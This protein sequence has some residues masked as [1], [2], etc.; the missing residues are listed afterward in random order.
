MIEVLWH[1]RGGQGAFTAA[2]LLGAAG[3]LE[4]G[5]YG[6][7]FPS[8]GPE[9]RGAPM[10]AFTK[11]GSQPVGDRSAITRADYTVFLDETLFTGSWRSE[12]KPGGLALVNTSCAIDEPDVIALDASGISRRVLGRDIPN[13]VFL[14]ALCLLIDGL[15]AAAAK[16]AIAQYMTP[17]LHEPNWAVVDAVQEL[18]QQGALQP[19]GSGAPAAGG[20][21]TGEQPATQLGQPAAA[22][23]PQGALIP[24]L[25]SEQLD[26]AVY[27]RSTCW[28]AGYLVS[29]NA[30]WRTM[31]PVLGPER[32]TGCLQCY[33]QCPDGTVFKTPDGGVAI[34]YDFCK[35]C[36]ICA[37]ACA[38][39]CIQ[40]VAEGGTR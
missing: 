28:E 20:C 36:G 31:R 15:G 27:A 22:Q 5:G 39:G 18:A 40:M 35:G 25:R 10:R 26:P 8:F 34:D 6:L 21:D 16:E 29:R 24:T 4:E 3:S 2:R 23:R 32:C 13:T 33:M 38:L 30:G 14:A 37:K 19:G 7:A 12:L 1:G 11:L 9:R 17:K